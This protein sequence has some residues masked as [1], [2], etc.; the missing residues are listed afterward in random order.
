MQ[1]HSGIIPILVIG[2]IVIVF[3]VA[4]FILLEVERTGI[5]LWALAFL[6]LSEVALFSGLIGVR[7]AGARRGN[8]F[9][10]TGV[11]VTLSLYFVATLAFTFFAGSLE[12]KLNVFILVEL[13]II[14][15]FAIITIAVLAASRGI[16]R[17]SEED[18]SKVG[19]DEPRRGGF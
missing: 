7:R 16:E 1:R 6:L 10:V 8:V 18:M 17:R 14:A 3:S 13:G 5:F 15:L 11:T 19:T 2:A 12:E 4:M 9:M